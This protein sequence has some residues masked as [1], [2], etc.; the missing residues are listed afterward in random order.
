MLS[1]LLIDKESVIMNKE[2][3]KKIKDIVSFDHEKKAKIYDLIGM[4]ISYHKTKK[5]TS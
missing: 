3:L 2:L 5:P 1:L 4:A